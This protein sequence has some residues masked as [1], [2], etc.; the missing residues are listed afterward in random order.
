[1]PIGPHR[2]RLVNV[3]NGGRWSNTRQPRNHS[4]LQLKVEVGLRYLD[5]K[6]DT[7][8]EAVKIP[9]IK[10]IRSQPDIIIPRPRRDFDIAQT[11]LILRILNCYDNKAI[12]NDSSSCSLT[13]DRLN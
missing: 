10:R 3:G 13:T 5:I 4:D 1:M 9:E 2:S 8:A 7:K 12:I 11:M 6:F